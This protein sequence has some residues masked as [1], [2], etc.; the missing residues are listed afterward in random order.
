MLGCLRDLR[1]VLV[2][3]HLI[4]A[5]DKIC[6]NAVQLSSVIFGELLNDVAEPCRILR[7]TVLPPTP[8]AHHNPTT[9]RALLEKRCERE[10]KAVWNAEDER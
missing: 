6:S 3:I 4:P 9:S 7:V 2:S 10:P 8:M 5:Q 1:S